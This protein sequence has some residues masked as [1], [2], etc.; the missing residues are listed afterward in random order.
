MYNKSSGI[1]KKV[2]WISNKPI[3]GKV[4]SKEIEVEVLKIIEEI[5]YEL[6]VFLKTG[7]RY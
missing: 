2:K 3:N 6:S 7:L 1:V 4:S 5:E